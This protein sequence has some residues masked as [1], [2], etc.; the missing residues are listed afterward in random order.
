VLRQLEI[1]G[2][3]SIRKLRLDVPD[4]L[5]VSGPNGCGKTNLYRALYL[6]HA[7]AAGTLARALADEGGMPS[8]LWAGK[9]R[10]A[11]PRRLV[12]D[13]TVDD[14]R[15]SMSL[16]LPPREGMTQFALDPLVKEER[17][18]FLDGKRQVEILNRGAA[19]AW[20]RDADGVRQTFPFQLNEA[21]SVLTQIA[22]PHRFPILSRMRQELLAWRFYHQF[23]TD[24]ESPLRRPQ[25]GVRTPILAHDG[26]DLAAALQTIVEVGDH[27]RL[28]GHI[29]DAFAGHSIEITSA[30]ARFAV[31]MHVP[32]IE[33]PLE[34]AELSDGVL[35]YLCLAAA[36]L[37]PRPPTLLA[38]N[39]P[40]TSLHQDLLPALG[41]LIADAAQRSQ[42]WVTTHATHL[43]DEI[44]RHSAC[45]PI[46][47]EKIDGET[48]VADAA[49][50]DEE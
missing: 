10:R 2:Y 17:L 38:L 28:H 1:E 23:R 34:A 39:E 30:D 22:E 13:A 7:A 21:E 27:E 25:L 32:G 16:G 42:I 44:A 31:R 15:Y 37:S 4:L 35:R 6:M 24:H 48:R 46:V 43:A 5:L 49:D 19:S 47:L 36:L 45:A 12:L 11:D 41:R 40:E 26:H 50:E 3:R 29:G 9:R 20:M 14:L 8:A 33:R 18:W